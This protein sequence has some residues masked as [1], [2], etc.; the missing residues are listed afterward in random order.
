MTEA[1]TPTNPIERQ[2]PISSM[3]ATEDHTITKGQFGWGL[4]T[5]RCDG[6]DQPTREAAHANPRQIR[7]DRVSRL[8][9]GW[10]P[11]SRRGW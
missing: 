1:T 3:T 2:T 8:K 9:V 5:R 11:R 10:P 4:F 7:P 6:S